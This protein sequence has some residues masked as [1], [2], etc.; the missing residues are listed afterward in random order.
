MTKRYAPILFALAFAGA[1][2][3][4]SAQTPMVNE[5]PEQNVRSS[6]QYQALTCTN[7]AFRAH[8]IEKECGP[9]QGSQFYDNCVAS[10]NCDKQPS[11]A[12]WRKAPP[13]ETTR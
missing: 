3:S 10:F 7:K 4:A 8:R 2:V 12:N 9:L 1:A 13:S 6:Q 5:T 11:A